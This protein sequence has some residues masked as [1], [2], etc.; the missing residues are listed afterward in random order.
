[1]TYYRK[2]KEDGCFHFV[3]ATKD[4]C[5]YKCTHG[6]TVKA[7]YPRGSTLNVTFSNETM[8]QWETS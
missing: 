6:Q 1:M 4:T 5:C 8:I 3:V 7:V 2:C